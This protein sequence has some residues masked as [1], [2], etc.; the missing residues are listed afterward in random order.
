MRRMPDEQVVGP[1]DIQGS[2]APFVPEFSPPP[3]LIPVPGAG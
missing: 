1:I 3:V 2:N